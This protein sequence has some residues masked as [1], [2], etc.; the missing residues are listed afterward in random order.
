MNTEHR[1]HQEP[2]VVNPSAN[3][4]APFKQKHPK[5][6][7]QKNCP[8]SEFTMTK[9]ILELRDNDGKNICMQ[10]KFILAYLVNA[11]LKTSNPPALLTSI[12]QLSELFGMSRDA[13][14][15]TLKK[16]QSVQID[17]MPLIKYCTYS[18]EKAIQQLKEAAD[19]NKLYQT[20]DIDIKHAQIL[21][22]KLQNI[23]NLRDRERPIEIQITAYSDIRYDR[24]RKGDFFFDVHIDMYK[25]TLSTTER[26]LLFFIQSRIKQNQN[27]NM[28]ERCTLHVQTFADIF[29]FYIHYIHET[30]KSLHDAGYIVYTDE[31]ESQKINGWKHTY[32]G[33]TEKGTRTIQRFAN[34]SVQKYS[35]E[36]RRK[37]EEE[38]QKLREKQEK[39]KIETQ[40]PEPDQAT[41]QAMKRAETPTHKPNTA[42][43][44]NKQ[45]EQNRQEEQKE[46]KRQGIDEE[47]AI[48]NRQEEMLRQYRERSAINNGKEQESITEQE[49]DRFVDSRRPEPRKYRLR[50]LK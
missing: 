4:S 28:Q 2:A 10:T 50:I 12:R 36:N 46:Q 34:G 42:V 18:K 17:G 26:V 29:N 32:V 30:L 40:Y 25:D 23:L 8:L 41:I 33:L 43:A 3:E 45:K 9:R 7:A 48:R 27:K 31:K 6:H 20:K 11:A 21:H 22:K 19:V 49:W 1:I 44:Q 39:I 35:R 14:H 47:Q 38:K 16:L 37:A 24:K 5:A 15:D 13:I